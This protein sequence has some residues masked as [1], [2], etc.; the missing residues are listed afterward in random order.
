M[1]FSAAA[2]VISL[3]MFFIEQMGDGAELFSSGLESF[4]LLAQLA[5]FGLLLAQH[6]VDIPHCAASYWHCRQVVCPRQCIA[7]CCG[8]AGNSAGGSG[9]KAVRGAGCGTGGPVNSD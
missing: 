1:A 5:L 2:G 7:I 4:N 6:F 3:A 9:L 8:Y